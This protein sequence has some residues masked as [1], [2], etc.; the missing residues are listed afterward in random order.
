MPGRAA[1]GR[2]HLEAYCSGLGRRRG[3]RSACSARTRTRT[4]SVARAAIAALDEIGTH[5]GAAIGS[6]VNIFG[7]EVVVVG[8]GFGLAAGELLLGPAREVVRREALAPARR[9]CRIVA[10]RARRGRRADRR[11]ARRLRGA[12]VAARVPLAV[13]ATPIGNLDDVTLRVLARAAR[14]RRRARRGHAA[15]ARLLDRHG[16]EARLSRYHEHNEAA[17]VAEL[18]PRLEAGERVA[19]VSRRGPAG[20]LRSG[21]AA[22]ARRR[23]TRA[24][25]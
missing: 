10:R 17:R 13:C 25:R 18:V 12:R 7:P 5:L 11:G 9:R 22:R 1:P 6:L 23:S 19:L 4:T 20:D 3:S 21:R 2:G 14:G 8:G 16:I 15:H 24:S